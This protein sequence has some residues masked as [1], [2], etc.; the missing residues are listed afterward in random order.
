MELNGYQIGPGADLNGAD[1]AGVDLQEAYPLDSLIPLDGIDL[2]GVNLSGANLDRANL[3]GA[4]LSE[5]DLS[6]ANLKKYYWEENSHH[7]KNKDGIVFSD[8]YHAKD[9]G[10]PQ[11]YLNLIFQ[12][13]EKVGLDLDIYGAGLKDG[14]HNSKT[15]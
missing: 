6:G 14:K 15:D 4:D 7:I 2:T 9:S 3:V 12:A 10:D 1:L 13:S 5:A 8:V 11:Y